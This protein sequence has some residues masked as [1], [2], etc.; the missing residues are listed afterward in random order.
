MGTACRASTTSA[1]AAGAHAARGG[2][3]LSHAGGKDRQLLVQAGG[4]TMRAEGALPGGRAHQHFAVFSALV[5]MKLVNRHGVS[6]VKGE[7]ISSIFDA[8]FGA[9]S[10]QAWRTENPARRRRFEPAPDG[11]DGACARPGCGRMVK[12][13]HGRHVSLPSVP[14]GS[15]PGLAGTASRR[16]AA[17]LRLASCLAEPTAARARRT[18]EAAV[19]AGAVS[20][21][22]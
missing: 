21:A 20:G 17:G 11:R 19:G 3:V 12:L 15:S 2:F 9:A 16:Q 6:I 5:T 14:C 18:L 1:A 4:S 10:G 13:V 7:L 8:F 22:R